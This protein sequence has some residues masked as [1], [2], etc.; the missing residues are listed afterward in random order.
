MLQYIA[1]TIGL[2]LQVNS[3]DAS[4]CLQHITIA[5][6]L[7]CVLHCGSSIIRYTMHQLYILGKKSISR[8]DNM[9][10]SHY[11]ET[12]LQIKANSDPYFSQEI[13]YNTQPNSRVRIKC[14][15]QLSSLQDLVMPSNIMALIKNLIT[16]NPTMALVHSSAPVKQE[17][18]HV[19]LL[20]NSAEFDMYTFHYN[21]LCC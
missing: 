12:Y 3:E 10:V 9:G 15:L 13:L 4:P 18:A 2:I 5:A 1:C 17:I 16:F 8:A 21:D 6:L 14:M 19:L 20:S 7:I 11:I